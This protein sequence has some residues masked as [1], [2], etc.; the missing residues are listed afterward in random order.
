MRFRDLEIKFGIKGFKIQ[1]GD[2]DF[3]FRDKVTIFYFHFSPSNMLYT[4]PH[5]LRKVFNVTD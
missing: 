4:P 5:Q 3:Q 1:F 2:I